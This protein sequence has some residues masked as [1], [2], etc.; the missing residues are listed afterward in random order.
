MNTNL[1]TANIHVY[2]PLDVWRGIATVLSFSDVVSVFF[3][4][5]HY[6]RRDRLEIRSHMA[7]AEQEQMQITPYQGLDL[8]LE[9][10]VSVWLRL[11]SASLRTMRTSLAERPPNIY[12]SQYASASV[13]LKE[14]IIALH[15]EAGLLSPPPAPPA[16]PDLIP[17][18]ANLA[19]EDMI[20]A[21]DLIDD[22]E[23]IT[24]ACL[25][26]QTFLDPDKAAERYR[27]IAVR[28]HL[29]WGYSRN[30]LWGYSEFRTIPPESQVWEQAQAVMN[31]VPHELKDLV[32]FHLARASYTS[33]GKLAV[34]YASLISDN[35]LREKML[36]EI[37][38]NDSCISENTCANR[39]LTTTR[40]RKDP[41]DDPLKR[42]RALCE[43]CYRKALKMR[44]I[45]KK[46][47]SEKSLEKI[48][49]RKQNPLDQRTEECAEKTLKRK[50][51]G[52]DS[53]D[54][55]SRPSKVAKVSDSSSRSTK[56]QMSD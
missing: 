9:R 17:T 2:L 21:D 54:D 42:G 48:K 46:T 3:Q 51:P 27:N 52:P 24:R 5:C 33:G 30:P 45:S 10:I 39:D 36:G 1:I 16:N 55:D 49:P 41:S 47:E 26:V 50:P 19:I 6:L 18:T 15:G 43:S 38:N 23:S 22:E 14:R 8:P 20:G 29:L 35:N 7:A 31:H 56:T 11:P 28:G 40:K 53:D 44:S 34:K 25:I 13:L 12:A 32:Y 4:T 37:A